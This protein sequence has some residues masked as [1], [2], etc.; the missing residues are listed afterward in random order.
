M[1]ARL[2]VGTDGWVWY[3]KESH[4]GDAGRVAVRLR[5]LRNLVI[6][7]AWGFAV[8]RSCKNLLTAVVAKGRATAATSASAH[9]ARSP[10]TTRNVAKLGV[11]SRSR[12]IAS[13][14]KPK[15]R[16]AQPVHS[17]RC[18]FHHRP[19]RDLGIT[20]CRLA[21]KLVSVASKI[22]SVFSRGSMGASKR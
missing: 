22:S 10:L 15:P 11:S 12:R 6:S 1:L 18:G 3:L 14:R 20:E 17:Y 4:K 2:P 16:S 21:N 5:R 7:Q 19:S 8:T 9:I 13:H